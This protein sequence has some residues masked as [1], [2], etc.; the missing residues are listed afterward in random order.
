VE[1]QRLSA[2]NDAVRCR[3]QDHA[4]DA[5]GAFVGRDLIGFSGLE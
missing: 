2:I 3:A 5:A 4:R 1:L